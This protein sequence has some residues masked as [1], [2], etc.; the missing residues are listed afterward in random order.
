ME[1]GE[2]IVVENEHPSKKVDA[3]LCRR[4]LQKVIAGERARVE[5]LTVVFSDHARVLELN[6]TYL[7]HDYETDVLAFSYAEGEEIDGEI[8]VDLDTAAERHEEFGASFEAEALRYAVHGLLHLIGYS[9]KTEAGQEDMR[10]RENGY[11]GRG[12]RV[13]GRG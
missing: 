2:T 12:P 1:G 9:D 3:A 5:S 4:V 13:G 6:R 7:G 10:H 11:L 8:Y